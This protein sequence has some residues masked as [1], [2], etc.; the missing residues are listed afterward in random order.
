[1]AR[2][3]GWVFDPD[4]GGVRI[5]EP[6]QRHTEQHIRRYAEE[7]FAGR[8]T[9]LG[10]RFRGHFCYIDTYTEPEPLGPNW[11]PQGRPETAE[12]R[13][14]RLR[15][16][17]SLYVREEG[18]RWVFKFNPSQRLRKAFGWSSTYRRDL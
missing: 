1:M 3:R 8:Y 6:V 4:S 18:A 16:F 7:H 5:P 17:G 10:I 2:K 12:E 13:L 15:N 14:E 9:R 11:P